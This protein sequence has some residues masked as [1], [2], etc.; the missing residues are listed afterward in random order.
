MAEPRIIFDYHPGF[1]ILCIALGLGYA[2][3]LYT[4]KYSWSKTINRS[5]FVI[6]TMLATLLAILL[7]GP[8]LKHINNLF[9]KPLF[10]ILYD[11]S[12]SIKEAADSSSLQLIKKGVEDANAIL[13]ES[14]YDV[15]ILSVSGADANQFQFAATTSDLTSSLK[16]VA[17]R[18]EG[19]KNSGRGAG[20]RWD[21]QY[22]NFTFIY[23]L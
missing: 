2:F 11:D 22:G 17:N 1:A 9:E 21:L 8:I 5:L 4:S 19:R 15:E 12:I 23:Y 3:L 6:R 18:Y 13:E 20:I 7:L 16:E 10:V 14:G